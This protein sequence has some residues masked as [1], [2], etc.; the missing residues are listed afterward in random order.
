[1]TLKLST[2]LRNAMTGSLGFAG[3]F[4]RGYLKIFT[5]AQPANADAA[6]TGTLLGTATASSGALTKETRATGSITLTG[7]SSGSVNTVTVGGLNIIPDGA[8]AYNTSL[9]QTASDLCDAINRNGIM[10]ATVSGAAVT[11]YGRPG[12]GVTT[13]AVSATLTTITASYVNMGSGV[14]GIA[15]VNALFWLPPAAGVIAKSSAQVWS[16]NGAATGT[17][18]WFRLYASDTAD[19]GALISGAP[20]YPRLDGS[21][22]T[23]GAD[24]NL[25]STSIV[26]GAPNTIDQFQFTMPSSA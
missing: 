12:T 2:G 10:Q 21:I 15:A 7:G 24:L 9:N 19:S 20:Y 16:F 25:A 5:G 4:N 1:M 18:G 6:E 23:S 11:L 14:T 8:V 17:A 26:S 3:A 13:A 22:G